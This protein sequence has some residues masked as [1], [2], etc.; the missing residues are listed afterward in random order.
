[1]PELVP[2]ARCRSPPAA[3]RADPTRRSLRDR[4]SARCR[5]SRSPRRAGPAPRSVAPRGRSPPTCAN[6]ETSSSS[7][8][9]SVG[10]ATFDHHDGLVQRSS[11]PHRGFIPVA[12]PRGEGGDRGTCVACDRVAFGRAP[13]DP[14]AVTTRQAQQG[15]LSRR[16]RHV[17]VGILGVQAHGDR[18]A[19]RFRRRLVEAAAVGDVELELHQIDPGCHLG[20]GMPGVEPRIARRRTTRRRRTRRETSPN[21]PP[22]R[23]RSA[24][25][26][27][28]SSRRLRL[29]SR[30]LRLRRLHRP[31]CPRTGRRS[32]PCHRRRRRRAPR[33]SVPLHSRFEIGTSRPA[34]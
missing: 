33:C 2:V 30:W 9:P 12:S 23:S 8:I 21:T 27:W 13:I 10:G 28:A 5:S 22:G 4:P 6:R 7:R 1:M 3:D 11:Q 17:S 31:R 32:A 34:G 26:C 15:D 16:Q 25:T 19:V 29:Q 14:D 24:S 18:V 20:D